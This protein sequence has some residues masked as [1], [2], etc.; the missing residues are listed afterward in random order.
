MM[1]GMISNVMC[2]FRNFYQHS[3]C[4]QSAKNLVV[5]LFAQLLSERSTECSETCSIQIRN[6]NGMRPATD[7]VV[8]I[9]HLLF[10]FMRIDLLLEMKYFHADQSDASDNLMTSQD[11]FAAA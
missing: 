6:R 2:Y 8:L 10:L 7:L 11:C 3:Q 1:I 4:C 9:L 5:D